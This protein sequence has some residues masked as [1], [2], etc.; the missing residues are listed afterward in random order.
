MKIL[1]FDP[2]LGV[3]GDMILAALIDLGVRQSY[4]KKKLG[5]IRNFDMKVSRVAKQGISARNVKFKINTKIREKEFIPLINKSRLS[6]EIKSMATKIIKRIFDVEKKVHRTR[7]LHLHELADADTLLDIVRA[8]VA[9]DYL[10]ID[11]IY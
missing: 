9:I 10:N 7:H 1:Y 2:I 11:K 6:S 4:L 8:L 3:S 5:F